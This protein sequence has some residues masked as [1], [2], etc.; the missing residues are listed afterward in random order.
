MTEH[1]GSKYRRR[2]DGIDGG[3]TVVD[4]YCVLEAFEVTCPAR[5][6]AIKKLLC[7]GL[8]GKGSAVQDL[9][10]AMDAMTR[11][12][13]MEA[14]RYGREEGY[15]ERQPSIIAP[16]KKVCTGGGL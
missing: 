13:E 4:V 9:T 12:I 10:E 11:A 5:Q 16:P 6:H 14:V 8:R 7:A 3:T 1:S 2:I 15:G